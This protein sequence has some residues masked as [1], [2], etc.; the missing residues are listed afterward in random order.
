MALTGAWLMR[1]RFAQTARVR[2]L[3]RL[4]ALLL[5]ALFEF[6]ANALPSALGLHGSRPVRRHPRA[7]GP[8]RGGRVRGGRAHSDR[9]DRDR[10]PRLDRDDAWR[11]ALACLGVTELLGLALRDKLV[12]AAGHPVF[13]LDGARVA[14]ADLRD[15][16]PDGT[17][18]GLR[19][20]GAAARRGVSLSTAGTLITCGLLLLV[21]TR[22]YYFALPS[23][24]P[25]W[26]SPREGLRLV[27]VALLV[28]RGGQPG[29]ADARR[30]RR[31]PRRSPNAAAWPRTFTTG[32][33]RI[34]RSSRPRSPDGRRAR[35]RASAHGRRQAGAGGVSRDDQRAVGHERD[36]RRRGAGGG[37]ARAARPL[38]DRDHRVRPSR[39]PD[40]A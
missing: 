15:R 39:R 38:R 22:L 35:R 8:D 11:C 32:S 2:D 24:S 6:C 40:P 29:A 17:A 27:A 19:R 14:T 20:A 3:L 25:Q 9:P 28:G 1:A 21:A 37:G 33:P 34:S 23:T 16:G 4:A 13:G 10:S 5:L 26:V 31:G 7:R 30:G 12:L 18:A 36:Q